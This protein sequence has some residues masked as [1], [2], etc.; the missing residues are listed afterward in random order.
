MSINL[1]YH[2]AV[3]RTVAAESDDLPQNIHVDPSDADMQEKTAAGF[4]IF[5]SNPGC[6]A[7]IMTDPLWQPRTREIAALDRLSMGHRLKLTIHKP[8]RRKIEDGLQNEFA[9]RA[10]FLRARSPLNEIIPLSAEDVS[11]LADNLQ[12]GVENAA[13]DKHSKVVSVTL[14]YMADFGAIN[15]AA[16]ALNI[17]IDFNHANHFSLRKVETQ[18]GGPTAVFADTLFDFFPKSDTDHLRLDI[19]LKDP[20]AMA[21]AWTGP[22]GS[23]VLMRVP[24]NA[25][26]LKVCKPTAH[27]PGFSRADQRNRWI[28]VYDIQIN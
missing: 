19:K 3:M 25:L 9:K 21:D 6:N 23:S 1:P 7:V 8:T 2:R 18:A 24:S 14:I 13:P 12:A 16:Q 4:E 26:D 22:D 15:P 10:A 27:A 28:N 11:V 20:D 17:H 5:S